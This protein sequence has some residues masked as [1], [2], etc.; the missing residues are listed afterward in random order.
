MKWVLYVGNS[1]SV[2]DVIEEKEKLN[3]FCR[4]KRRVLLYHNV[5]DRE[6]C[7]NRKIMIYDLLK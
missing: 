4:E 6:E 2:D 1:E 7:S 5:K 3:L